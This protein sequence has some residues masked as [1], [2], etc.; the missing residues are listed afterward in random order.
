VLCPLA[1]LDPVKAEIHFKIR[2]A[3]R[4]LDYAKDMAARR[5][6]D[7]EI[8]AEDAAQFLSTNGL[9]TPARARKLVTFIDQ[10]RS[11]IVNYDVG[12]DLVKNF[13]EGRGGTE[14][15]PEMRWKE[16]GALLSA[17]RVPSALLK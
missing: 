9:M 12:Y 7:G 15:R 2:E 4:A 8:T 3:S 17:P 5:Y 16:L 14:D 1:G 11:Y 6:L 10:Y 13:I